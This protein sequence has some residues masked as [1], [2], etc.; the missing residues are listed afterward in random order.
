MLVVR[1]P[2][3]GAAN[4][5]HACTIPFRLCINLVIS[6]THL[7]LAIYPWEWLHLIQ[8]MLKTL[9]PLGSCEKAAWLKNVKRISISSMSH[10]GKK[11][12][13]R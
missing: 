2:I 12:R 7:P 13:L 3:R 8:G 6:T 1:G 5:R 11:E 9:Q 4:P 10:S